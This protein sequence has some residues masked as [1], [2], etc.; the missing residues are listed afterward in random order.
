MKKIRNIGWFHLVVLPVL[1]VS[2][3]N[4]PRDPDN[5]L[6]KV[7]DATLFAGITENPP[8]VSLRDSAPEGFEVDMIKAFAEELNAEVQWVKG[9]EEQIM[10]LLED[11]QVQICAGGFSS[12]SLWKKHVYFAQPHDTLIYKWGVP[13]T[14]SLPSKLKDKEVQVKRGS[15][16]ATFVQEKGGKPV[17][18]DSLISNL[19][20]VAAPVEDLIELNYTVSEDKLGEEKIA[21]AISHGENAFLMKLENFLTDYEKQS[22]K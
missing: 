17:F 12:E 19:P 16:A 9:S 7:R 1:L 6:N 22:R 5:T 18:I 11:N 10:R 20:L 21:L 13:E 14:A 15:T 2:C 8:Y 4:F 3:E